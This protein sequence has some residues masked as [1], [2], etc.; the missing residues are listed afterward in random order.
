[1]DLT[2]NIWAKRTT[3]AITLIITLIIN[4]L[5][6]TGRMNGVTTGEISDLF[7]V[8]FVPAAYVFSIWGLIYLG[9][10][11]YTIYQFR[12]EDKHISTIAWPFILSNVFNSAWI[13]AWH[14]Q[15]FWLSILLMFAILGC[16]ITIYTRLNIGLTTASAQE[17]LFVHL[18]FSI[19]LGWI[20]VATI[21]NITSYL[22]FIGWSGW[23]IS[24][25]MWAVIMLGVAVIVGTVISL[26][27][28]DI[29]YMA[30]LVWAFIGIAVK[31]AGTPLVANGAWIAT[32]LVIVSLL[33]GA[34]GK[35]RKGQPI[36][37]FS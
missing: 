5:A 28:G 24:E 11:A 2:N 21:A 37:R 17:K 25:A 35:F 30:V 7:D 12:C 27:R 20:T 9:L 29:A 26:S 23:G 10:I 4:G 36:L 13:I 15:V 18:P 19:Y 22:D 1:M 3:V 32:I 8:F 6:S 33:V 14:Y 34:G 31:H 16:L